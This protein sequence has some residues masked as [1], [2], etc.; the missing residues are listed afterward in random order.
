MLCVVDILHYGALVSIFELLLCFIR[1]KS[2]LTMHIFPTSVCMDLLSIEFFY[3]FP[4]AL[5]LWSGELSCFPWRICEQVIE[6]T[7][8]QVSYEAR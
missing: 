6:Q 5:N 2:L 3:L 7:T 4:V 1:T 8:A